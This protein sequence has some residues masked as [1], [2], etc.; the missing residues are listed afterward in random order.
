ML[1]LP[2]NTLFFLA[3]MDV[4]AALGWLVAPSA[5][6]ALVCGWL[7]RRRPEGRRRW[8]GVVLGV[9]VLHLAVVVPPWPIHNGC[10]GGDP[11][12]LIDSGSRTLT[13]CDDGRSTERHRVSLGV[14]GMDKSETVQGDLRT[15]VGKYPVKDRR[16]SGA[17]FLR[18]IEIDWDYPSGAS[19]NIG[20]HGP[21]R[22]LR[23]LGPLLPFTVPTAGCIMVWSDS[24]IGEVERW[25]EAHP[26]S[27][28]RIR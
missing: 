23:F 7:V 16:A 28:V 22:R 9:T 24:A 4:W 14:A 8:P 1:F 27:V 20:I 13:L 12:V 11:V 21:P 6:V 18:F 17:G 26:D 2:G 10:P 15:P 3:T 19:A 25:L 5:L